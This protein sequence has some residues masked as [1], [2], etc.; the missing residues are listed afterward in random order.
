MLK[1]VFFS[2]N[3]HLLELFSNVLVDGKKFRYH[4]IVKKSDDLR[5][6]GHFNQNQTIIKFHSYEKN[7][8]HIDTF[9][10]HFVAVAV[11]QTNFFP[12]TASQSVKMVHWHSFWKKSVPDC[13]L[14]WR[15]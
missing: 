15:F 3:H 9:F 6:F 4:L 10:F 1:V 8:N 13:F 14:P 11:E 12:M 7:R 2:L 5:V